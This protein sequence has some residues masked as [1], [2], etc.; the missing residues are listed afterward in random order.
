MRTWPEWGLLNFFY[1]L[2]GT[3]FLLVW[4][5][6]LLFHW[7]GAFRMRV[8]WAPVIEAPFLAATGILYSFSHGGLMGGL[9]VL[10]YL[11]GFLGGLAGI[12][13]HFRGVARY[14]GGFNLRNLMAG[15]P[16]ILPAVFMALALSVLIVF[17]VWDK[18]LV[19]F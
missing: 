11:I 16:V 17:F 5:Q 7:R 4:I 19:S 18:K 12:Y 10:F 1:L 9:L 8:M 2:I 13:F 14:V 3:A 6:V 15:P